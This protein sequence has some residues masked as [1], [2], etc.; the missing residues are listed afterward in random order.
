MTRKGSEVRVLYGPLDF[1]GQGGQSPGDRS[2]AHTGTRV[3]VPRGGGPGVE[4]IAVPAISDALKRT[5]FLRD[6]GV[7]SGL[8]VANLSPLGGPCGTA[9]VRHEH[10]GRTHGEVLG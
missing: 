2:E 3:V 4:C 9:V 8:F 5:N 1:P 6:R 7:Q 10:R